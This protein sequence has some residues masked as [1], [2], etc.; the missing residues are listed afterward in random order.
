MNTQTR[1]NNPGVAVFLGTLWFIAYFGARALLERPLISSLAVRYLIAMLPV[2]LAGLTIV[3]V[4]RLVRRLDEMQLRIQ[5]IALSTGFLLTA[6]L[7]MALA[8]AQ[9]A[10][11][12]RFATIRLTEVWVAIPAI[13]FIGVATARRR[14]E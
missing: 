2:V 13:Y 10:E 8:L 6:L 14:F 5:V 12:S 4:A 7:L 1:R 9:Y 3:A 11:P